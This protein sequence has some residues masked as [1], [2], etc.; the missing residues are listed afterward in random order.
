M[1][2][3]NYLALLLVAALFTMV[4]CKKS[5]EMSAVPEVNGVKVDFPTLQRTFDGAPPEIQQH[6]S[7]AIAGIRYGMYEKSL[8]ALD[9]LS[10]DAT[11]T[12][13][14][15]KVVSAMIESVKQLIAKAPP[16]PPAQ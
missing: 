6:V 1:K 16:A 5:V 14:Q 13:D 8:E 7:D 12:A 10:N 4:G 9:K 15:K 11:V 3:V 2:K